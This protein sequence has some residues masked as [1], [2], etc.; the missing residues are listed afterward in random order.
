M[1][2]RHRWPLPP[3]GHVDHLHEGQ[4]ELLPTW[5]NT[6]QLQRVARNFLPA[7]ARAALRYFHDQRVSKIKFDKSTMAKVTTNNLLSSYCTDKCMTTAFMV[8]IELAE[9]I[10]PLLLLLH[11]LAQHIKFAIINVSNEH[12]NCFFSDND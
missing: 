9:S 6:F 2:E 7:G 10:A 5:R 3:G 1:Q 4:A 8:T 12:L 11:L